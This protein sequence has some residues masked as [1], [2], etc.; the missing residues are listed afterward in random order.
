MRTMNFKRRGF[1][2]CNYGHVQHRS[3][4]EVRICEAAGRLCAARRLHTD[5]LIAALR[6]VIARA[7]E[8][9]ARRMS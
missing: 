9:N 1:L 6:P 2:S 4:E 3:A 5:E 7:M 8:R